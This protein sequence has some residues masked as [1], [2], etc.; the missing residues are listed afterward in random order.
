MKHLHLILLLVLAASAQASDY[1]T[2][3]IDDNATFYRERTD[4]VVNNFLQRGT[5]P[6]SDDLARIQTL[7]NHFLAAIRLDP[8]M[9]QRTPTLLLSSIKVKDLKNVPG[10]FIVARAKGA[11]LD[12]RA[13]RLNGRSFRQNPSF[14]Q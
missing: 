11:G 4:R 3:V 5:H 13:D 8:A 12:I 1:A 2:S 7:E 9:R 6:N 10:Q 14:N